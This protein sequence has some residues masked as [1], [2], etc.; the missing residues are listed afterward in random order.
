MFESKSLDKSVPIPLYY[1]LKQSLEAEL[2]GGGY[3]PGSMI[4]TETE[5]SKMFDVSRT[6][7]R[8]ALS[9]LTRDGRLYRVKSK[10]TFV[11]HPKIHQEFM[12]RL[13][14]YNEEILA[15][16]RT[17]STEVLTLK[18]VDTPPEISVAHDDWSERSILLYRRRFANE[19]PIVCVKSYLPYDKCRHLLERDFTRE[20]L[21]SVLSAGTR[22][23]VS[24]VSRVCEAV[25]AE[26]EDEELLDIKRGSPVLAIMTV[27]YNDAEEAIEYSLARYAGARNKFHVELSI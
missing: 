7:V 21:Y 26:K 24:H 5:L 22:T 12:N 4:P 8:Q 1:Q 25:A 6:T 27:G 20:S 9:D 17:P 16:G 23:H 18:A 10:G 11:A 13:Q 14:S 19:D 15:S 3:P 2:D